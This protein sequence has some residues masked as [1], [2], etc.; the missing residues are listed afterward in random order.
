M[1]K[2]DYRP[3]LNRL[4][5]VDGTLVRCG[6]GNHWFRQIDAKT[7]ERVQCTHCYMKYKGK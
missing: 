2:I 5:R 4:V 1:T 7:P 3:D 6:C